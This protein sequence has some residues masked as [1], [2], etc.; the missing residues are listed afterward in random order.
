MDEFDHRTMAHM[1][2]VLEEICRE[3]KHGGDHESR[4]TIG[5]DY[6]LTPAWVFKVAYEFDNKTIGVEQ[7]AFY[8]QLGLGL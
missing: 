1:D 5:V 4:Y 7:S 3:L 2:I 8:L 6:W